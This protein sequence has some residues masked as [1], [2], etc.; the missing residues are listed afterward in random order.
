VVEAWFVTELVC[1]RFGVKEFLALSQDR[2]RMFAHYNR[3]ANALILDA[4]AALPDEE[5]TKQRPTFFKTILGTLDHTYVIGCIF[6][7]HLEGRKHGYTFRVSNQLEPLAQLADKQRALDEWYV[8]QS[9]ND[10]FDE[11]IRFAFVD[12]GEA[13][14]TRGE[15]ILHVI[16]H[17]TY[18]RGFVADLFRQIPASPPATDLTVFIRDHW[19]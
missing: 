5:V 14:M 7:A 8:A 4:V 12:G 1:G 3:W 18:H 2:M 10:N 11:M 17:A 15:M 9:E 13:E 6:Q 19:R 16:N